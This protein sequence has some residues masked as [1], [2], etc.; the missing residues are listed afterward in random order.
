MPVN[1][2]TLTAIANSLRAKHGPSFV[3]EELFRE[4]C[5]QDGHAVIESIRTP[6]EIDALSR[7]P[8]FHLLAVDAD[9]RIRYQRI[10]RRNSE[11]D[12][13]SYQEF[14]SNEEREMHTSDPNKQNLSACISR[15]DYTILNNGDLMQLHEQTEAFLEKINFPRRG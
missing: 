10:K 1:R 2:D 9:P 7:H 3:I 6:G 8:A 5:R 14:L 11:T 4:A 13:I 12:Q 15:A